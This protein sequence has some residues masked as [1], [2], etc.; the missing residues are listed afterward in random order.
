[1]EVVVKI[2]A[3]A[4]AAGVLALALKEASPVMALLLSIAAAGVL[5]GMAANVLRD[6]LEVMGELADLSG[7][8]GAAL[9]AITKTVGIAIAT[10]FAADTMKDAGISSAASA[11]ELAGAAAG[12]FA[13]MPLLRTMLSMIRGLM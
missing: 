10:R 6:V 5:L 1:M 9:S 2:A 11:A 7:M 4:L 8:T 12:L 3:V 13:C